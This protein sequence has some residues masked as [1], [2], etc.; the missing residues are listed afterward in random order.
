MFCIKKVC[1]SL[2]GITK[3]FI[4]LPH[5]QALGGVEKR[6]WYQLLVHALN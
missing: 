2:L 4:S 6:A 5:T 3:Q 1:G